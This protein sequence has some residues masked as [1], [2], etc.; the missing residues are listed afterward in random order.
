MEDSVRQ[1]MTVCRVATVKSYPR[2]SYSSFS[3]VIFSFRWSPSLSFLVIASL[4]IL[5]G[6][7]D[8]EQLGSENNP[9]IPIK[10]EANLATSVE[11]NFEEYEGCF[12][13]FNSEKLVMYSSVRECLISKQFLPD[14]RIE[15]AQG[16]DLGFSERLKAENNWIE[17]SRCYVH[18]YF[19]CEFNFKRAD[20][21]RLLV[22]TEGSCETSSIHCD[23]PF[24]GVIY[25]G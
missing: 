4:V 3:V 7:S 15:E 19:R 21:E 8:A 24:R 11:N 1:V 18:D 14:G 10:I 12:G 25:G 22:Y 23:L 16:Y 6:C 13:E 9:A 2:N 20:G 17:I 5:S